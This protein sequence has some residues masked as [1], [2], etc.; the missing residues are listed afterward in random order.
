MKEKAPHI[1]MLI[2]LI[3]SSS[4]LI[5]GC[6]ELVLERLI[7]IDKYGFVYVVDR[8][9]V[10]DEHLEVGFPRQLLTSLVDYYTPDGEIELEIENQAFWLKIT[11]TQPSSSVK[12]VTIFGDLVKRSGAETFKIEFPLNPITRKNFE[13]IDVKII[14]PYQSNISKVLPTTMEVSMNN[15]EASGRLS[16]DTT[17]IQNLQLEFDVGEISI[18]K[19]LHTDLTLDLSS[20][21][22]EYNIKLSLIDGKTIN[23]FSFKL[24][25]GSRLL[26]TRDQLKKLS[27]NYDENTGVLRVSFDRTLNVGESQTVIIKFKPP[28]GFF[29]FEG[30]HLL[31]PLHL[32][33][34]LSTPDYRVNIILP[35]MEYASS[36]V[37]P[38]QVKKVYPEKTYLTFHLGI[39][40]PLTIEHKILDVTVKRGTGIFSLIPVILG[41]SSIVLTAGVLT[42]FLRPVLKPPVKRYEEKA[43]KLVE[44]VEGLISSCNIIGELIASKKIVDKGHI[45]QRMLEVRNNITRYMNR[46][47][48]YSMD[49]RKT[50][51]E[52]E[53]RLESLTD[54]SRK[55]S[56][57]VEQ[58]WTRT[59]KYLAGSTGKKLF[60][61]QVEEIYKD[62][63]KQLDALSNELEILRKE[64]S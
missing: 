59:Y 45:R 40:S 29:N 13:N 46:I 52:L 64:L 23:G 53:K 44:E 54:I 49:L 14:L 58:L 56:G 31:I 50:Y 16:M 51:P 32:P 48:G 24:H 4:F 38:I 41:A 19:P 33:F 34:N 17:Q 20:R 9:P 26:E 22:A 37:E 5:A 15:R 57:S 60:A 1:I 2:F 47:T 27:S 30:E 28:E 10:K 62:I 25:N 43:L 61:K 7:E 35:S 11:P 6:E 36:N 42:H 55:I 18:L 8:I 63:L 12:L 3:I 39:V 21:E